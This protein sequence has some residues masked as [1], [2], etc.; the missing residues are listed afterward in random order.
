MKVLRNVF[1]AHSHIGPMAPWKYYDLQEEVNPTVI[2][3]PDVDSYL[4]H[5]DKYGIKKALVC[6]NYG[7]PKHEQPFSLNPLVIEAVRKSDRL[8]GG[9]WVSNL[10]RNK[11]LTLEALKY[12]GEPGIACLKMTY[13][14]GGNPDPEKYDAEQEELTELIVSTCEKY[15]LTLQTHSSSGGS[16]DISNYYKF[17]EKYGKRIRIHIIHLGGGVSGHI[18]MVPKFI[19]WVKEGYQ[20]YTDGCWAIGFG[21]RFLLDEIAK[22]GVGED[23]ILWGS[24]EPWSD[25]PSEYWKWEGADIS[26]E[27]KNKIFWE[28]AERIYGFKKK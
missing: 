25:L 10:P 16:S 15:D 26:E 9:I 1:D 6:P 13:L 22:A 23:R 20:V 3:Y 19:N 14:L 12:A 7:I 17:I 5:M 2:E 4:A 11:E 21:V 8:L 27:F 24:D 28:N 18:K